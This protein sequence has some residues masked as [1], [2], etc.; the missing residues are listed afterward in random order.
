MITTGRVWK[1]WD[2]VSTDEITPGRYN[3][4]K[5]PQEL[6]RIAFIEV[7]PEF[8]EKVRRGDVVVG[9]KNFGIGS[10]RESAALALKAAGV[11]GI[12]A[13]SFGRIFYRNAVNLGIPLLIGDTDELE[14]GDVITV[15]WETGEVRK[16]GQTLQFEPLPGFLLEIVREGGILEFIRRRGDLCIG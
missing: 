13:K 8:A 6:A 9:G 7:R 11:S 12:I 1:F 3:L 2:N 14:D 15:N 10:S 4:T 16:N 5:D